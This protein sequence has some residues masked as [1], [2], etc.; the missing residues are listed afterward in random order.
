MTGAEIRRIYGAIRGLVPVNIDL[1][2]DHVYDL[3]IYGNTITIMDRDRMVYLCTF[4]I[5][6]K[7]N[8]IQ[9]K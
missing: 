8:E 9:K 5:K 7:E 2:D 4:I 3:Q 1:L 6:N